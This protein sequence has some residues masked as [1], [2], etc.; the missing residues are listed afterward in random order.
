MMLALNN[1]KSGPKPAFYLMSLL[2]YAGVLATKLGHPGLAK[3][4][5]PSLVLRAFASQ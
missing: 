1:K 3:S 2:N 5:G 4:N